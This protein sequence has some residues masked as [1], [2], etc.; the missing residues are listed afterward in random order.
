MSEK[1]VNDSAIPISVIVPHYNGAPFVLETL[2]SILNQ[3]SPATEIV[4]VDDHSSDDSLAQVRRW[5]DENGSPVRILSTEHNS[6]GPSR[7]TNLGIKAAN[8]PWIAVLDQDDLFLTDRLQKALTAISLYPQADC[9]VSRGNVLHSPEKPATIGQGRFLRDRRWRRNPIAAGTYRLNS[10][11]AIATCVRHGMF[12]A[13]YPGL[14]F[15]RDAWEAIGGVREDFI[16][17]SD[18]HFLLALAARSGLVVIDEPL[19][20]R[21]VHG[22]NLSNRSTLGFAEVLQAI[23]ERLRERPELLADADFQSALAWRIIESGWNVA[24]FGRMDV[25]MGLIRQTAKLAGWTPRRA[26]QLAA[27]PLMPVYRRLFMSR[28]DPTPEVIGLVER[29]AG[30]LLEMMASA[31]ST[32]EPRE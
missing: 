22:Q 28:T 9:I 14:V 31:D 12:A 32:A 2:Q 21:R 10:D 11:E 23:A 6:G 27:T 18:F 25:G 20:K 15:R 8:S 24:A 30:E 19:Y 26:A 16:V 29:Y 1:F 13:G 17:A 3:S 7:P 4:L 5:N